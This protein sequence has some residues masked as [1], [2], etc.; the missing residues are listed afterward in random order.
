LHNVI[1]FVENRS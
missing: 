1:I